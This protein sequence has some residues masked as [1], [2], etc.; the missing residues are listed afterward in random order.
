MA[1]NE[2]LLVDDDPNFLDLL[3]TNLHR[4]NT[5]ATTSVEQAIELI[6]QHKIG[7]VITDWLFDGEPRG[8]EIYV[9]CIKAGVQCIVFTCSPDAAI[10]S[11]PATANIVNKATLR[12]LITEIDKRVE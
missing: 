10:E 9:T 3:T 4:Y 11:L 2:I 1:N 5:Q 7:L 8:S 6:E 12:I